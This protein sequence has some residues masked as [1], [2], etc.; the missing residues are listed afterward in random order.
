MPHFPPHHQATLAE[1]DPG[2]GADDEASRLW[3]QMQARERQ[4][5][6]PARALVIAAAVIGA[7]VLLVGLWI[8]VFQ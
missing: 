3:R 7:V 5:A 2:K 4:A 8:V 1:G 6:A